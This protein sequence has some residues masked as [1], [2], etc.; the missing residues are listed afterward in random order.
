MKLNSLSVDIFH[1]NERTA[2]VLTEIHKTAYKLGGS[3][4]RCRDDRFK[5]FLDLK[6]LEKMLLDIYLPSSEDRNP[7]SKIGI[8]KGNRQDD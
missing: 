1:V 2:S 6:T 4:E 7:L 8:L 3:D 5:R